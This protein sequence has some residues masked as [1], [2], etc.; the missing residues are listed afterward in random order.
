M[1]SNL[2]F[3]DSEAGLRK[4]AQVFDEFMYDNTNG[5]IV[6]TIEDINKIIKSLEDECD[7]LNVYFS[8][9]SST[10]GS[11]S[12]YDGTINSMKRDFANSMNDVKS[13]YKKLMNDFSL[14][15]IEL[16]SRDN[17]LFEDLQKISNTLYRR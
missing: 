4:T 16:T 5:I 1:G 7:D 10:Y 2:S 9:L 12:K 14:A 17:Q 3:N 13:K 6:D 11:I 8:R 15:L